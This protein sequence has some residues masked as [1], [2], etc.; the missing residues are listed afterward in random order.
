MTS[1]NQDLADKALAEEF[2]TYISA[3]ANQIVEP[4]KNSVSN[5][6][7][8]INKKLGV[9][10]ATLEKLTESHEQR[11]SATADSFIATVTTKVADPI[12]SCVSNAETSINNKT[13]QAEDSLSGLIS[14][15]RNDFSV[16]AS[17]LVTT[18]GGIGSELKNTVSSIADGHKETR[19]RL[20]AFAEQQRDEARAESAKQAEYL[21][22]KILDQFEP[23]LNELMKPVANMVASFND[24]NMQLTK[25]M[26]MELSDRLS[27]STDAAFLRSTQE[28]IVAVQKIRSENTESEARLLEVLKNIQHEYSDT[29]TKLLNGI[30]KVQ[31]NSVMHYQ[32]LKLFVGASIILQIILI[33]LLLIGTG[34]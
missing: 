29:E 21:G 11:F 12:K 10:E 16:A 3:V 20:M 32:Q 19:Q 1:N 33:T 4:I 22:Q 18:L 8:A 30:N 34:K 25:Q 15:H 2:G 13:A 9:A 5:A 28:N 27:A 17:S 23:R 6:E 7:N 14:S 26:I 24:R 31:E